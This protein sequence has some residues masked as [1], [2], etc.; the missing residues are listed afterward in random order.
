MSPSSR[1]GLEFGNVHLR[2][3]GYEADSQRAA[4]RRDAFTRYRLAEVLK[5]LFAEK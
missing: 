2:S 5:R 3:L 1:P 4:R